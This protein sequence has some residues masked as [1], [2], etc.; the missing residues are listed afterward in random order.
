[1]Q[2][3]GCL[4]A[5]IRQFQQAARRVFKPFQD[6]SHVAIPRII[7]F[8]SVILHYQKLG[9]KIVKV[10]IKVTLHF[11]SELTEKVEKALI[12]IALWSISFK[13]FFEIPAL[14]EKSRKFEKSLRTRDSGEIA[15]AAFDLAMKPCK[16]LDALLSLGKSV[17]KLFEITWLQLF[18]IA[19]TP[20]SILCLSFK[21]LKRVYKITFLIIEYRQ[22]IHIT[23]DTLVAY[24]NEKIGITV[25]E[26]EELGLQAGEHWKVDFNEQKIES[27]EEETNGEQKKGIF[28]KAAKSEFRESSERLQSL[29][30]HRLS[31]RVSKRIVSFM[32][33][34][35]NHLA[36]QKGVSKTELNLV[37]CDIRKLFLR[38]TVMDTGKALIV[39]AQVVFEVAALVFNFY[40]ITFQLSFSVAKTLFSTFKILYIEKRMRVGLKK[41][42]FYPV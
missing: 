24:L 17:N 29:K 20:L 42:E 8:G 16:V 36:L 37:L 31:R 15:W 22:L 3:S 5:P 41:P 26:G 35:K 1:M 32:R 9:L 11:C 2:V 12:G 39:V 38:Q 40:N 34:A 18:Q 6:F 30:I 33:N 28:E 27:E 14:Y 4:S 19:T 10:S 7:Y 23:E 13:L 21:F 25:S